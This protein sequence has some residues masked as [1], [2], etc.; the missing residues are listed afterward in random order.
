MCIATVCAIIKS[1]VQLMNLLMLRK[2]K[3]ERK[4]GVIFNDVIFVADHDDLFTCSFVHT[5]FESDIFFAL[6]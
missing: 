5:S 1:C 6:F 2:R 3:L 4:V